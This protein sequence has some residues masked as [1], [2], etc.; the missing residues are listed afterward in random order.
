LSGKDFMELLQELSKNAKYVAKFCLQ[1]TSFG[2]F[3]PV[4]THN[5]TKWLI[6]GLEWLNISFYV[7]PN[8]S[9]LFFTTSVQQRWGNTLQI[10]FGDFAVCPQ[11]TDW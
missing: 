4:P 1:L 10:S 2:R 5:R 3:N 9:I 7:S 6:T 8:A 11:Q